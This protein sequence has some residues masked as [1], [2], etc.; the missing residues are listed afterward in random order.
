MSSN[1]N[2]HLKGGTNTVAVVLT[3]GLEVLAILKGGGM[4]P[5]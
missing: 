3:Q 2:H 1:N 5:S 4:F